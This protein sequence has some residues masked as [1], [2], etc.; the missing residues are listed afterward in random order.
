MEDALGI[1]PTGS[2][3][4]KLFSLAIFRPAPQLT[5]R[6]EEAHGIAR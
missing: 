1:L 3:K 6:L 2:G 5:E 4:R